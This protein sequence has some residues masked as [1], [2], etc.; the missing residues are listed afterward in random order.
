M[1]DSPNKQLIR[2]TVQ[3]TSSS[4]PYVQNY[5]CWNVLSWP[6]DYAFLDQHGMIFLLIPRDR[7]VA[8]KRTA[9][10][11]DEID[12]VDAAAAVKAGV[13]GAYTD[14]ISYDRDGE[15]DDELTGKDRPPGGDACDSGDLP[16]IRTPLDKEES[17]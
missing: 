9:W 13:P 2:R 7:V 10:L 15:L 6:H 17:I 11:P 16:R 4:V 3:V 5:E 8:V 1:S 14:A 12:V